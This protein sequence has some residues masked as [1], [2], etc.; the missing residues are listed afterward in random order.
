MILNILNINFVLWETKTII[1][2]YL[3]KTREFLF[4]GTIFFTIKLFNL[5]DLSEILSEKFKYNT[6]SIFN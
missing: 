5:K 6:V 2:F 4:F 3:C 1:L